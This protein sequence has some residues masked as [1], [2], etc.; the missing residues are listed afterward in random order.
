MPL[1]PDHV[2]PLDAD[3]SFRFHCHPGVPCFTECCRELE[4][5][6]TPYDVLRLKQALDLNSR[7]FFEHYGIIEFNQDDLYPKV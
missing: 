6:L 5:G 3:G 1:L 7:Q 2:Q 4:L